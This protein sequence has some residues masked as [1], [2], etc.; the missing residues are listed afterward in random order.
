[1]LSDTALRSGTILGTGSDAGSGA[2]KLKYE[3]LGRWTGV[4]GGALMNA[5][6]EELWMLVIGG[7][8]ADMSFWDGI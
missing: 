2:R 4:P 7:E 8:G 5:D 6:T 1:M 3:R